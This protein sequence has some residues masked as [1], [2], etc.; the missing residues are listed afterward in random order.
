MAAELEPDLVVIAAAV[1]AVLLAFGVV[2]VRAEVFALV[3]LG[4]MSDALA[5]H[6]DKVVEH[7][8]NADV[9]PPLGGG[10]AD[11]S[12]VVAFHH[13]GLELRAPELCHF[14]DAAPALWDLHLTSVA[15]TVAWTN[16]EH[17]VG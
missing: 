10:G 5:R 11:E 3:M 13:D 17:R 8:N 1:E 9:A 4:R 6:A 14:Q 16:V 2:G 12:R 15:S 7:A